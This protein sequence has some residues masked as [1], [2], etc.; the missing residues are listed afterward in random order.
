M[1]HVVRKSVVVEL[2]INDTFLDEKY[3]ETLKLLKQYSI[4]D[5]YWLDGRYWRLEKDFQEIK[6]H[7]M[8]VNETRSNL[9]EMYDLKKRDFEK[10][11]EYER[12]FSAQLVV[13]NM[14]VQKLVTLQK[15]VK[16]KYKDINTRLGK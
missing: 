15:E 5:F 10:D 12:L 6:S 3:Q 16:D 7:Y 2:K 14:G 13:Y 9:L 4:N 8:L 11:K 1:E